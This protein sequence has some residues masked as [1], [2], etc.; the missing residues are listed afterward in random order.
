[1]GDVSP[2]DIV[3]YFA[4]ESRGHM[5]TTR[6]HKFAYLAQLHAVDELAMP[7]TDL[8]FIRYTH[9]PWSLDLSTVIEDFEAGDRDILVEIT[10][11]ERGVDR[12]FRPAR[13]LASISW[14]ESGKHIL[15]DIWAELGYVPSEIVIALCKAASLFKDTKFGDEIAF[16][17]YSK[18]R[19]K[20][21]AALEKARMGETVRLPA[22]GF[23]WDVT[24]EEV[25]FSAD[26]RDLKGV[27]TQGDTRQELEANMLEASLAFLESLAKAAQ[28]PA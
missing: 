10:P 25:G 27:V 7:I 28:I 24:K 23:D 18:R 9:G 19:T 13:T 20:A 16:G 8:T 17:T 11:S 3:R 2:E 6:L 5:S 1:M 4:A 14:T 22:W 12:R 26:N 21:I 15:Q